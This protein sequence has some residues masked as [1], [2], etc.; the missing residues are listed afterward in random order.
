MSLDVDEANMVAI[1]EEALRAVADGGSMDLEKWAAMTGPL[2]ERLN[3][4]VFEVFPMPKVPAQPF[5]RPS[6]PQSTS[7]Q[8]DANTAPLE[9]SHKENV[10][11]GDPQTTSQSQE[12]ADSLASTERVP[13]SQTQ[14]S[15]HDNGSLP[16]QLALLLNSIRSSIQAHFMQKP[17]H[18]IQRFAELILHPTAHY[19]TLPAYLR[20]VDR[21]I[22]VTSSADIFPFT[23]P[24]NTSSQSNG[25]VQPSNSAG[26]YLTPDYA[27]SLGS[28]ESLGGALLTPI[29][30]LTAGS[31]GAES[32]AG[33]EDEDPVPAPAE[34][35]DTGV[36]DAA[37]PAATQ[38][39]G[40]ECT[41]TTTSPPADSSDEVPHARGPPVV[42]VE[43]LGLQDGKG[44]E[45]TLEE[46]NQDAGIDETSTAQPQ[47]SAST[48]IGEPKA[49]GET[50]TTD[51]DGDIV[52]EDTKPKREAS[53]NE[54]QNENTTGTPQMGE[55]DSQAAGNSSRPS[56]SMEKE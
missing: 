56:E 3:H 21:V 11:P 31:Y 52:P 54:T 34:D 51:R 37:D 27:N 20:A 17:P 19:R 39:E 32:V 18:T 48:S 50:T 24:A 8:T 9:S 53:Q 22:S 49:S 47:A 40:E 4:I 10:A 44:V 25:F 55:E 45:M 36:P 38:A 14:S 41:G 30:W 6:Y 7:Q 15:S 2:L 42:G 5:D 23:T 16:P 26:T 43:D 1:D 13:D 28:D 46:Q 35:M 29:P 12:T 33:L